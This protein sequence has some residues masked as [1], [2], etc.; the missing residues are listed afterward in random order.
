MES[1]PD[2]FSPLNGVDLI[3]KKVKH[4]VAMAGAIPSGWEF[5]VTSDSVASQKV[6]ANWATPIIISP[7]GIGDKIITG[8]RLISSD[9]SETP[10]KTAFS[11]CLRQADFDG[12]MSW[13]ETAVL[14]GVRG[15]RDYFETVKGRMIVADNGS[16]TWQDDAN[17]T[18]EY[19]KFKMEPEEICRIIEDMMMH[20][21]KF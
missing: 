9:I 15:I 21:R 17:G 10:A 6:F 8:K 20:E 3:Q 14:V 4:L 12:R 19:L 7:F 16:N 13:D 1:S 18:H 5:N 11:V 2:E